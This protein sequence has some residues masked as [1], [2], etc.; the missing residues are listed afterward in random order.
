MNQQ[1]KKINIVYWILTGLLSLLMAVSAIPD[2][3]VVPEAVDL[4]TKH[5]GYPVYFLPFIGVAKLLG[6]VALLIPGFPRIKEWV[7]AGFVYDLTAAVYSSICVGD[8]ASGWLPILIGFVLIAAAYI[9]H[10]KK[11][12]AIAPSNANN[13]A[14]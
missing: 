11:L 1:M 8:P 3:L 9:F 12:R 6:A 5:L 7:Y 14:L 2:I 4:V 13:L 10:H